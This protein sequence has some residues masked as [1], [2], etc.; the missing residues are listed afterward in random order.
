VLTDLAG[1][2]TV[3]H[4]RPTSHAAEVPRLR[5]LGVARFRAELGRETPAEVERIVGELR[6]L[7]AAPVVATLL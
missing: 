4:G 1:R 2:S 3:L 6:E 5:A 7:L